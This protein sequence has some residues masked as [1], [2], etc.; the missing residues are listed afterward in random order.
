MQGVLVMD[1]VIVVLGLMVVLGGCASDSSP[2]ERACKI[3]TPA[4]IVS[5]TTQDDQRLERQS[6]SPEVAEQNC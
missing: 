3:F 4:D 6:S 5:P 1:K 2:R